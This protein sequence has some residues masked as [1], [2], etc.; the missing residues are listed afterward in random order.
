MDQPS[1]RRRWWQY[2]LRSLLLLAL[3]CALIAW[4]LRPKT[5]DPHYFPIAVGD[6]WVY[7]SKVGK[8]QQD[9][10]FEVVGTEKIGDA[11]CFVVLRTI[12][13]HEVKFY[14]EVNHRGV[15]IH[16]VGDDRYRPPYRQFTFY[17]KQ[18]DRW[19]WKGLIGN[20][21]AEYSCLNKGV[22]PVSVPLGQWDAFL[23][24]QTSDTDTE[25]SLVEGIG[26]VRIY[27]KNRDKHD[28][29]SKPGEGSSFDWQLKEFS[30]Q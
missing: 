19:N 13:N 14:V 2:S 10:V 18:E 9:V 22:W 25:F 26:V 21:R 3:V 16:Q 15:F 11:E 6:R 8:A 23:V 24:S 7:A 17:T 30:R 29:P 1:V 12:G 4:W 27:S 20:E 28:P 5:L